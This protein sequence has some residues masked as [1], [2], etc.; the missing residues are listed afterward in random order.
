VLHDQQPQD[1]FARRPYRGIVYARPCLWGTT[2]GHQRAR[3]RHVE[4]RRHCRWRARAP[5]SPSPWAARVA[6]L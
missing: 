4:A 3:T 1:H 6:E 2:P 5:H